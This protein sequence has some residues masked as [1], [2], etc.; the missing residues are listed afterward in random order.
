MGLGGGGSRCHVLF[1]LMVLWHWIACCTLK[2]ACW[3]EN[4]CLPYSNKGSD[5]KMDSKLVIDGSL[6]NHL[7]DLKSSLDM[8]HHVHPS[9]L[10]MSL[11][12]L[13]VRQT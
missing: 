12:E 5:L 7:S 3:K 2:Y 4:F 1:H 10:S 9:F 8:V 13:L 11:N 6:N